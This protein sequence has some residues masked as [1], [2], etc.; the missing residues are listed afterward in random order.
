MNNHPSSIDFRSQYPTAIV[1]TSVSLAIILLSALF[2][3][4]RPQAIANQPWRVEL[5]I[6]IFAIPF[7][8]WVYKKEGGNYISVDRSNFR[9]AVI[10]TLLF[11]LWSGISAVWA[12]LPLTALFQTLVWAI[13]AAI[14]AVFLQLLRAN[15]GIK[16][17]L[18]TFSIAGG[19]LGL[20]AIVDFISITDFSVA[21]GIIRVR[22][23]K[24][25]ELALTAAPLICIA[26]I[27]ARGRIAS[28]GTA[29]IWML[30]WLAVMLSLSKGAFVAGIAAHF[31]LFGGCVLFSQKA[32]RRKILVRATIWLAFTIVVQIAFSAFSSIPATADYI[33]GKA[34]K[35]RDTSMFRVYVWQV[36]TKMAADHWFL[37]VGSGNFGVAFN[38]SRAAFAAAKPNDRAPEYGQDYMFERA[39][40]EVLQIFAELGIVGILLFAAVFGCFIFLAV[41][42]FIRKRFKLSPI[43][44]AA[45]AGVSGFAISSMVSSFSFRA[46]QNGVIFVMVIAVA[47]YELTKAGI[48][49]IASAST[50]NSTR[51]FFVPSLIAALLLSAFAA[52]KAIAEYYLYQAERTVDAEAAAGLFR[53]ALQFDPDNASAYYYFANRSNFDSDNETAAKMLRIGIDKGIGVTV[54]YSLLAKYQLLSGDVAAAE[55]T[56]AEAVR[57]FPNS[58]FMRVRFATF[59]SDQGKIAEADRE[60]DFARSINARQANGWQILIQKGST[61][62]FYAAN[63]DANLAPPVELVPENAVFEYLDKPPSN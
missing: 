3:T 58:V 54:T 13:Y 25:A 60:M 31:I 63:K 22:Y 52:P 16:V 35:T 19:I 45:I 1:V 47:V 26:S 4:P 44:W 5:L 17:I 9:F 36:G 42:V 23:A 57:I 12:P 2:S 37:G 15:A 48:R 56:L 29:I 28:I 8:V 33:S 53:T 43:L 55:Q 39:H 24:F 61:V 32:F 27:Y 50:A 20:L 38:G 49:S 40:N 59:L 41:K 18:A 46:A 10:C 11:I 6:G 51:T 21:Q 62:A 34:D 14:F 7:F 30:A